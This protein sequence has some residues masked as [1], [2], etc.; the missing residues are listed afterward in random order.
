MNDPKQNRKAPPRAEQPSDNRDLRHARPRDTQPDDF[1][2]ARQLAR[3]RRRRKLMITRLL[4]VLSIVM[5]VALIATAVVVKIVADQKTARGEKVRFLAVTGIEVE[6]DV[7]YSD[8]EVIKASKLYVGQSLLSLNKAK[9]AKAI[10]TSLPYLDGNRVVVENAS[11]STLRIKVVEVP[12]LAAVRVGEDW[13][14]LG[15]NNRAMEKVSADK[16]PADLVRVQGASF[17]N[18]SV[19][20]TLLDERSLRITSTLIE[21]ANV[22]GLD[23]MTTIDMTA[24]TK[25]FIMLNERM[26]VVLGNETNL[27]NQIKALVETLPTLYKN[28]GEDA[29]GRLD[30][31]FY[32][33][34][35]KSNN[36]SI[37]TPQEV[38]DKLEQAAKQ[39]MA[40][41]QV[42]ADWVLIN[43]DN[44]VLE[45]V[46]EEYLPEGLVRILGASCETVVVGKELLDVNS[47]FVCHTI[48]SEAARQEEVHLDAVDITDAKQVTLRL[49]EGLHVLLGDAGAAEKLLKALPDILP[50]VW[51]THGKDASGV[52]DITSYGDSN[53][54]NDK[55]VYTPGKEAD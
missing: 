52:A 8:E 18:K 43:E 44:V 9:A 30:M 47:L 24:R 33:D 27:S 1:R 2:K 17:E 48:I 3:Q 22:Y 19:G 21:A 32:S 16:V 29:A 50:T 53:L 4:I 40:A 31:V 15:V 28:N 34:D 26:Q 54:D 10:V 23:S 49:T 6:G 39:P 11:F 37:Y 7:R 41:V 20:K 36:K 51:E 55:V 12:E 42:G 14:I 38:L 45:A 13:M 46:P 5:I 25:I 35:D